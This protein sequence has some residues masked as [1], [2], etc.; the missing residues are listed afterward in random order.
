MGLT[1]T[2]ERD[3]ITM[4]G[5]PTPGPGFT[6]QKEYEKMRTNGFDDLRGWR[7]T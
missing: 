7:V 2:P 6:P 3:S 5:N 4:L 1:T